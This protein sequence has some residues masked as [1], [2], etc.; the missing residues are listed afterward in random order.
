MQRQTH[1]TSRS[2]VVL[3]SILLLLQ[4]AVS[5]RVAVTISGQ[6]VTAE[7]TP[8]P[9]LFL[10]TQGDGG[11]GY[12]HHTQTDANGMYTLSAIT[13]DS[14]FITATNGSAGTPMSDQ[15]LLDLHLPHFN[16]FAA[17]AITHAG[18]YNITLPAADTLDLTVLD[19]TGTP[20]PDATITPACCGFHS[21][22]TT[23]AGITA[24]VGS[25]AT[26]VTATTDGTATTYDFQPTGHALVAS[27]TFPN[28]TTVHDTQTIATPTTTF[29]LPTP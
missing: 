15:T 4:F 5:C 6:V 10:A 16:I 2:L 9:G 26:P 28:G 11:V 23:I 24:T 17:H 19:T 12:T 25:S 3:A 7:G 1:T 20:R 22:T 8:V 13:G 21:S 27:Y 14:L 18:T 29:H